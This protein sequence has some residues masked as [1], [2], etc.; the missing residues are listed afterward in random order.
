MMARLFALTV[1]AYPL[2]LALLCLGAGLL[3]DRCSGGF[4]PAAL[5][6]SVGAAALIA[7]SQLSTD[8][9]TMAP[10]T[11]YLA[12]AVAAAGFVAG[13]ARALALLR[14]LRSWWWL[15]AVPAGV[16]LLALA[17]VLLGGR[18]SFS[19]F[20]ALSDSAV[21]MIGADFL[22][23]HGRDYAHLDLRN[24]YGQFIEHYYASSYPS[25]ADT[26]LGASTLLLHLPVI[27]TFQPFN[28][29]ILALGSGPA[30]M[31]A[32]SGGLRRGW[33]APAALLVSVPALVYGYALIGSIKELT[34]L[35]M[36]LTL[37]ALV[38]VHRRWLARAP[39][40][41]LPFALVIAAGVSALGVG[42]GVWALVATAPLLVVVIG[43]LRA[44]RTRARAVVGTAVLG[45]LVLAV[46]AWPSWSDLSGSLHVAQSISST[47]NAGNLQQRLKWTQA[48]GIWLHGSYKQPP[49]GGALALTTA[50]LALTI[51]ACAL[52]AL[53]LLR[54]R[55]WML[56][57]WI[58]LMLLAWVVLSRSVTTWV[59]AKALVLTSP[60]LVLLACCGVAA[61]SPRA[62]RPG[63]R[64]A[65]PSSPGWALRSSRTRGRRLAQRGRPSVQRGRPSAQGTDRAGAQG[66]R[67]LGAVAAA[68]LALV[69]AGG[70]IASDLS[71]YHSSSLAPTARY[72]EL[73]LL[74]DR[75]G[76][77]GPVLFL[78]F[79]EYSMY[80]LRDLDV[81]GPDFV[82]PPGAL[83]GLAS[84]YGGLIDLSRASPDALRGY[85]LIITRRAP[86]A[87]PPPAAY[88]L[89]WQGDYYEL[90]RRAPGA[91]P[92][93][94]HVAGAGGRPLSC[95]SVLALARLAAREHARLLGAVAGELIGVP[96]A[97]A[98]PPA[99][100]GR[101]R[102]GFAMRRPG[103]LTVD[104]R[105]PSAGTWELWLQGQFMP[106][107][108][109]GVDGRT[110]ATL[111]GQLSGNSL[112]PDTA[113]P[114]ALAL[115]AG[116]HQL[117]VTRGGFSLAP[118]NGV[119]A[120]LDAAVLTPAGARPRTLRELPLGEGARS[121][122]SGSYDWIE[123]VRGQGSI[124]A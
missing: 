10:W 49:V 31:L 39:L 6:P 27:W 94:R 112:V 62:A 25:G 123:L 98:A 47:A 30:W 67:A 95:A 36:I 103:R 61:L 85:P 23:R 40:R 82:Y 45:A 55:R 109:V 64:R 46:G 42:F 113:P 108:A 21:H 37:G 90:W 114:I 70:V 102:E 12:T 116:S 69:L 89:I 71:Q 8:S 73:A 29:L 50:L 68:G 97:H 72:E 119:A 118:G 88:R 100:W 81:G 33:A 41:A 35:A 15:P 43:D 7:L 51:A 53:A 4:L 101:E 65:P 57:G 96:I 44:G 122:C 121:L 110:R 106:S 1:F 2:A 18:A 99:G 48:F 38:V 107:V 78:D 52:G 5:L 66:M 34:A 19:S 58:A 124:G 60:V 26:L 17:P 92:A 86:D 117:T 77:D 75:F 9:A 80:A 93:L 105:L 63:R 24:S 87:D 84:R 59:D 13:R 74:N 11:P 28:A 91:E 20:M 22:I 54:A 56:A 111:A 76:G 83:P 32:R 115:S 79:D 120:V 3:I 14:R 104:F 16:Y